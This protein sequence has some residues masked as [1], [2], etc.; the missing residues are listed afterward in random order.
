M[1][2]ISVSKGSSVI[3]SVLCVAVG[4]PEGRKRVHWI[5]KIISLSLTEQVRRKDVVRGR[6]AEFMKSS[7]LRDQLNF[8]SEQEIIAA[9]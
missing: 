1:S 3:S 6:P 2:S 4:F 8:T 9:K 5:Y 7:V